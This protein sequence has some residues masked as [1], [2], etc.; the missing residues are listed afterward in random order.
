MH[1]QIQELMNISEPSQ[2]CKLE[3]G[4]YNNLHFYLF[5]KDLKSKYIASNNRLAIDVGLTKSSDVIGYY[6]QDFWPNCAAQAKEN[7]LK[8]LKNN[9]H[10]IFFESGNLKDGRKVDAVSYKT[11]WLSQSGKIIGIQALSVISIEPSFTHET[12]GLT[13]RQIDC[14]YH[15]VCGMSIKHIA[16]TLLL[17]PRTVEHY[18]ETIKQKMQ[19]NSRSELISNALKLPVI[20]KLLD[21]ADKPRDVGIY[22]AS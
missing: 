16:K 12:N 22:P 8:V 2:L 17:S 4:N 6:D 10:T 14:L 3:A 5:W 1:N 15:L 7:D 20:L 19:C 13:K 11:P 21:P 18:I 9:Q